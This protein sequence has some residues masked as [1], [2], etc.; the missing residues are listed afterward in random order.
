MWKGG[1]PYD[2]G[3]GGE[4]PQFDG[5]WLGINY[6]MMHFCINRHEAETGPRSEKRLPQALLS[7]FLVV[8]R[9]WGQRALSDA[10]P[11]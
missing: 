10:K 7:F 5:Q 4:P 2:F 8:Y 3:I 11:E 1:G 9:A 6:E